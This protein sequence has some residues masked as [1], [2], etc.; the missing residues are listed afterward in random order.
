MRAVSR[1]TLSL[2][3]LLEI[4]ISIC[5]A[6]GSNDL[7][8]ASGI[9]PGTE[10]EDDEQP[11]TVEEVAAEVVED[12]EVAE[13]AAEPQPVYVKGYKVGDALREVPTSEFEWAAAFAQLSSVEVLEFCDY[14]RVPTDRLTGS[15][16]VQPDPAFDRPLGVLM[17]AMQKSKRSMVVKFSVRS[18]Q[19]LG[20]IRVRTTSGG[21]V[22]LL[23]AVVFADEWREPDARVLAPSEALATVDPRAV[24][25]ALEI[26]ADLSGNGSSLTDA[27]DGLVV[28]H[29]RIAERAIEG[30]YDSPE[31]VLGLAAAIRE[32]EKGSVERALR[33]GEYVAERWPDAVDAT[34]VE[35]A[36]AAGG[37]D[38]KVAERLAALVG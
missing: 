28:E 37:T 21:P 24:E 34:K 3:D 17:A 9:R 15:F 29:T 16:Y 38:G 23:N 30:V 35:K 19:H 22:L 5:A 36:I 13:E 11:E 10:P 25:H 14:R 18:R 31:T 20:V 1:T 12:D 27:R 33:L 7:K 6:T 26:I 2:G 32:D 8:W 4:P